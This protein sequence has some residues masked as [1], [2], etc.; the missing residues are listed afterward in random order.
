ME[1]KEFG[2][3]LRELRKQAGLTQRELADRVN[4]DFSYISKIESG[5]APPPSE[6]VILQLAEA[7]TA[8]KDEL[9]ILAGKI[10][11]D[12][13]QILKNRETLQRLRSAHTRQMTGPSKKRGKIVD[14]VKRWIKY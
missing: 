10:P 8:D 5:A 11:P 9:S 13:A 6:K 2:V 14:T 7:L 3:R 12:I 4:V 1:I